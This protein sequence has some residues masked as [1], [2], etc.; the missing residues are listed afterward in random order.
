[1]KLPIQKVK[2]RSKAVR[3]PTARPASEPA[4]WS[5]IDFH[6]VRELTGGL[7]RT[8]VWRL[9]G[10]KESGFPTP[11]RVLKGRLRWK[12]SEVRDWVEQRDRV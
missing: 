7:S 5:L 12:L 6:R 3:G 4:P 11:V 10:D 8:T 2:P 1:M 9:R